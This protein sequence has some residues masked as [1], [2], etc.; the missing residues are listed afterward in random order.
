MF[1]E[2][3]ALK[4]SSAS[5]KRGQPPSK[6]QQLPFLSVSLEWENVLNLLLIVGEDRLQLHLQARPLLLVAVFDL[7][8]LRYLQAIFFSFLLIHLKSH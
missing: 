3:T 4:R 2:W 1:G 7:R 8:N 5:V 6:I